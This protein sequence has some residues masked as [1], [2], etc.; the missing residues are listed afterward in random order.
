M[1]QRAVN[2]CELGLVPSVASPRQAKDP[3]PECDD[4]KNI[5]VILNLIQNLKGLNTCKFEIN[6]KQK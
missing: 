5:R 4:G 3:M 2:K 6:E 1:L